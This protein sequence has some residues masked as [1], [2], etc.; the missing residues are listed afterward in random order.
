MK[1]INTKNYGRKNL[2][3][4]KQKL[5]NVEL[6]VAEISVEKAMV[7]GLLDE[8][9][10]EVVPFGELH[11][12]IGVRI[13]GDNVVI[14]DHVSGAG[15]YYNGIPELYGSL[16][17]VKK[18]GKYRLV[19]DSDA[20]IMLVTHNMLLGA[21]YDTYDSKKAIY[22]S[23]LGKRKYPI[24]TFEYDFIRG[25]EVG[26]EIFEPEANINGELETYL[27]SKSLPYPGK[28]RTLK[29]VGEMHNNPIFEFNNN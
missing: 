13:I 22:N 3:E 24:V 17:I 29:R 26:R 15:A 6:Y 9:L 5:E 21:R 7:T 8:N 23:N 18:D 28:M 1:R 4:L 20:T 11:R 2:L 14:V 25:R 10:E 12:I 27:Y 19:Y 16:L